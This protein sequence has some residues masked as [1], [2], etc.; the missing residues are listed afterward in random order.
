MQFYKDGFRGGNPDVKQAAPNRRSRG[1]HE[2]LPDKVDVL[3]AGT[4]PAGLCLAAQLAQFPEIDTM[5][6]ERMS[7]NIVKG[8][9]DGINTRTMEMFQA[10]GFAEKVARESVWIN[11]TT[12]WAPGKEAALDRVARVQDVPDGISEMPHVLINQARVHDMFLDVMR[13]SPTRLEPHYGMKIAIQEPARN[14]HEIDVR[15]RF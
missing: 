3:I 15:I 6:V 4:G 2:P 5:I 9:A 14:I 13:H 12:F 8:K 7:S 11:E 10:F 1:I